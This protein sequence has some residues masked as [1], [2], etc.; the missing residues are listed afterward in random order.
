MPPAIEDA[1]QFDVSYSQAV[2]SGGNFK[3]APVRWG[4]V[5]A[6]VENEQQRSLIHVLYYPLNG[7]G[8]PQIDQDT[9]GRFVIESK[10]FLDPAIYTK[11]TLITVAGNLNGDI[12]RTIG[13]KTLNLPLVTSSVLHL[14]PNDPYYGNSTYGGY[15]PV[16]YGGFGYYY[17]NYPFYG[18]PYYWGGYS[19]H[20]HFH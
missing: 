7:Y 4:G 15:G 3:S 5:I 17:P 13:Q 6:Q 10:Q 18:Y 2:Q 9:P 14:W 19:R 12:Q 16:G 8:R 11:D 20:Y 1:P